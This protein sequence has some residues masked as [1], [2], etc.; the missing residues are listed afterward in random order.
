M[1]K[2]FDMDSP[3]MRFLN[4][5]ADL[6]ILNILVMVCCIPIITAGAAFT[7]MHYIL[8]KMVRGEEGYLVRN[9]FKSFRQNFKQ[10]TAI[11]LIILL[12]VAVFAG[13]TLV[14]TYSTV[15]FPAVFKIVLVAAGIFVGMISTYVFPL[16][17]RFENTVKNTIKNATLLAVA[18][19]PKTL[20]M[21]VFYILPLIIGYMSTYSYVFIFMFGLS[22]PAYAAAYLYS[23]I[24]KKFE[25]E[26][27]IASDLEFSL[28]QNEEN[29]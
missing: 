20:A 17:A 15:E 21:V 5:V 18:N 19:L 6:L 24:F 26:E 4:R 14:F 2:I 27:Q 10:A 1:N 22:L 28:K 16:L 23:E 25:P 29:K 3:F 9:F 12:F 7:A 13:D 8:L 11:W